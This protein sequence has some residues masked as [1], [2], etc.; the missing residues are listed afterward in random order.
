M[1]AVR[2]GRKQKALAEFNRILVQVE[3]LIVTDWYAAPPPG[4]ARWVC[5]Q[6]HALPE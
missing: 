6:P 1:R 5:G 2:D 3:R 4:R